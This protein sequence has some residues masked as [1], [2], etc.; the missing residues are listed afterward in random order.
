[1]SEIRALLIDNYRR[2]REGINAILKDA[3]IDNALIKAFN[4]RFCQ[5]CLN[6]HWFIS[7]RDACE[8]I[9]T[10]RQE[11]NHRC[12]HSSL[13]YRIPE[14]FIDQLKTKEIKIA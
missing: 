9:E 14:K 8:K 13:H 10:G 4:F 5:G 3:T 11:Y 2:L 6:K 7:L 1:M 12:P